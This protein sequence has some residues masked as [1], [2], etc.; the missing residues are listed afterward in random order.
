MK[1]LYV[2][3]GADIGGA[4]RHLLYLSNWFSKQ[5]H[6]VHVVLGEDGPFKDELEKQNIKAI[7]IP[8]PRT[9]KWKEDLYALWNLSRFIQKGGYDVVHSHSSKAGII[10]RLASFMNRVRKNIYT[11]HGF[12]FNDPTLTKKKKYF[13]LWLEKSFSWISSHIITVSAYDYHQG[14]TYGMKEQKLSVIYNGIPENQ[15]LS[16]SEWAVKQKRLRHTKRKIIGFVGRFASEKNL[17]M[18]LRVA[19]HFTDE[20]VEFWLIGDGPLF[21]HYQREVMK[22]NLQSTILL[23]GSQDNV[24][25]WMDQMHVMIITSHKE[26]FPYVFVEACGRGLPVISTNVGGIKEV[27]DSHGKENLLVP[28]NGDDE[29]VQRLHS[30]LSD[31]TIRLDLGM[32]CLEIAQQLT[33]EQMCVKTNNVYSS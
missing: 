25:E 31:D 11:A 9:I 20:N 23:K 13:Y 26:G 4:Q 16:Q 17:D 8:I 19:S 21:N 22:Q 32:Y 2:I 33:V 3:T 27:L 15:I 6:E 14:A 28:I 7:V 1:I 5:G 10:A 24:Y 30:I 18:L 12:V 29:M